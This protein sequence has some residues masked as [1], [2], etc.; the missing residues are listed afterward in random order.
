MAREIIPPTLNERGDESH[1]A[2]GL[3]GASRVSHSP[4]GAALFDSDMLHSH[5]VTIRISTAERHRDLNRD[6]LHS[7]QEFVE[8]ALSEAQWASFVSSMNVGQGVPCTILTRENLHDVPGFP[9][10]PRL[11]E[12]MREV[13]DAADKS[14]AEVQAAFDAYE[15]KKNAANLRNLKY[16]IQNMPANLTYTAKSLTEHAENVVQ[17]SR[18]DIE[19]MVIQKAKQIGIEPGELGITLELEQ[20]GADD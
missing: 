18:A 2:W 17:R 14:V 1:P 20:G 12:S 15:E 19:A 10:E 13:R 16:A 9:H 3:I 8:I 7:R 4:P 5:Y 6:W 11:A